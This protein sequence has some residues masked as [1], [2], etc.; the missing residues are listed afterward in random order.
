MATK[1]RPASIQ[2]Q[3]EGLEIIW[4][5]G[6]RSL[7]PH[8]MLRANCQCAQC[9]DEW[10]QQRRVGWDDVRPDVCV[11]D[12]IDVGFYAIQILWSDAHSTGIY[13]FEVLRALC[14]CDVCQAR[15]NSLS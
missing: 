5:D 1:P 7:Y 12:W 4:E 14:P 15:R 2:L 6:H 11:E 9:V 8:R 3:E 13:P 10:T